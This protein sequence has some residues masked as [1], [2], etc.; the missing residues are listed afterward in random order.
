[1]K[2]AILFVLLAA[3]DPA[4][5]V[6]KVV[7][8][9]AE[10]VISPVVGPAATRCIVDNGSSDEL[11]SLARDV[12]VQ[13]GTSTLATIRAIASRPATRSCLAQSGLPQ[14]QI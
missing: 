9:T 14:L 5:V 6:D 2:R 1:M 8:R 11:L 7:A 3:C 4:V 12:A 10:S 13:A